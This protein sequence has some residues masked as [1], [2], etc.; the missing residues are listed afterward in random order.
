MDRRKFIKATCFACAGTMAATWFLQAC[1]SHNY[2][3]NV[4]VAENKVRVKKSEFTA[5]KK[6]KT[7]TQK[8]VLIK[9]ESVPF[10]I[11]LYKLHENEYKA[12]YLQCTHQGCE[13]SA[14]DAIVVCPCHGAEFN[15]KGEVTNGPA[16]TNLKT[17]ETST[18][19]DA[20]YIQL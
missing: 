17:F 1:T 18:D 14:H 8:L 19:D 3:T 10:L 12:L 16:E 20:V 13:L 4:Q 2:L 9:L 6:G 11:A 7:I 15:I 5:L